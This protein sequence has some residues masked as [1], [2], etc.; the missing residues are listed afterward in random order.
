MFFFHQAYTFRCR[1]P[2]S[3]MVL[4]EAASLV[5]KQNFPLTRL[6]PKCP[7]ERRT[8]GPDSIEKERPTSTDAA[9]QIEP[10]TTLATARRQAM[11]Q[12][13]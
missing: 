6:I 11:Q 8:D 12:D 4:G 1:E 7:K 10:H 5:G 9:R 3:A 13:I 2:V